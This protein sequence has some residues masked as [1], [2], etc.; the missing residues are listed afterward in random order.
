MSFLSSSA[1]SLGFSV[2]DGFEVRRALGSHPFVVGR[3]PSELEAR[4]REGFEA[5]WALHPA[6]F[7]PVRQPFTGKTIP[8]PRWQQAY[9]RDYKYTGSTNRALPLP[10]ALRPWV[11]W[12]QGAIL[13]ELNGVLLNWYDSD[14]GHYIGPHRDSRAGLRVGSPIV[15]ISLGAR[16]V[17]RLSAAGVASEDH[18]A[19][20]GAVF[21][22]PWATNLAIKHSVPQARV[23]ERGRRIS[24][25]LRAFG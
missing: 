12:A 1:G 25:T 5:L 10:D 16:R 17:F 7:H 8:L 20:H 4:G 22:L 13:S 18:E 14:E 15:T 23:D 21:V 2:P 19:G 6:E 9:E 24:I 11:E 3:L